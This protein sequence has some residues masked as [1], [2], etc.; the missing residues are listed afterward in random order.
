MGLDMYAMMTR[1]TLTKP[2]DFK[3]ENSGE[4]HYW[5][6]HPDLHGWMEQL[7]YEKGGEAAMFNCAPVVLTLDDLD[8]LENDIHTGNLPDTRGFFFGDSDGTEIKDDLAF[9]AKAREAI[10]DG[11]TVYYDSWW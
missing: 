2:V 9:I 8:A 3:V 10:A 1:E 11:Y 7:Y 5:R 4:L 6:K